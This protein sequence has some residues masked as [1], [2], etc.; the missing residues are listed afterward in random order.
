MGNWEWGIGIWEL[1]I[2]GRF[3]TFKLSNFPILKLPCDGWDE[4]RPVQRNSVTTDTKLK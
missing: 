1:G 4:S 2:V 3:G